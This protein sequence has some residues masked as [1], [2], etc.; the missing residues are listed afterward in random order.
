MSEKEKYQNALD[1]F[2]THLVN[3]PTA[4]SVEVLRNSLKD[5]GITAKQLAQIESVCLASG[6][7]MPKPETDA[8]EV[9]TISSTKKNA[10]ISD[11]VHLKD[12]LN[13]FGEIVYGKKFNDGMYGAFGH[14]QNVQVEPRGKCL[15]LQIPQLYSH[16]STNCTKSCQLCAELTSQQ[17]WELLRKMKNSINHVGRYDVRVKIEYI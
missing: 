3:N 10:S 12:V 4:E 9:I 7:K 5:T 17:A 11:S 8:R 6:L 16:V 1:E 15:V 13:Q 14:A 2:M